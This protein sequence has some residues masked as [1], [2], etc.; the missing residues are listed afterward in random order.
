MLITEENIRYILLAYSVAEAD[1]FNSAGGENLPISGLYN[2]A[3]IF[4][5][6]RAF[7]RTQKELEPFNVIHCNLTAFNIHV[8][9]KILPWIDH[10]YQ[11]LVMNVDYAIELWAA[12]FPAP[13][14]FLKTLDKADH[15]FA[16]EPVMSK[17]LGHLLHREVGCIPHPSNTKAISQMQA[18]VRRKAIGFSVHGYDQNF[19]MPF[20]AAQMSA[21]QDEYVYSAFGKFQ[22]S[23]YLNLCFD[24]LAINQP[25]EPFINYLAQFYAVFESYALH[26][27]GR[28]TVEAAALGV[29]VVGA[30]CVHA[31]NVCFRELAHPPNDPV[32]AASQMRRLLQDKEFY[33][34]MARV[35]IER[36]HHF[37]F[38]ES[39]LRMLSFLNSRG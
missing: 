33:T 17:L 3:R 6:A 16:V 37:S 18:A 8:M 21:P 2:W 25:F 1:Q 31:Q 11:K 15:V 19:L 12:N 22:N 9:N 14:T 5:G 35:G 29:P 36:S 28:T 30:D 32:A 13:Q 20:Y 24:E 4:S 26:S 34:H 38:T 7:P 10:S 23:P 39:A 27:Y